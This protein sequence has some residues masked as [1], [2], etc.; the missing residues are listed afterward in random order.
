MK[1]VWQPVLATLFILLSLTTAAQ[2]KPAYISGKVLD[3]DDH[4]VK[5]VSITLLNKQNRTA[6]EADDQRTEP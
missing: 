3:E 4:P 1:N 6:K 5:D 2:K